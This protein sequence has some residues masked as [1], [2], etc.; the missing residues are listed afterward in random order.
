[1]LLLIVLL[2]LLLRKRKHKEEK[3]IENYSSGL[4][5]TEATGNYVMMPSTANSP[6]QSFVRPKSGIE[7]SKKF[8][9]IQILQL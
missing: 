1:M 6:G 9:R 7:N 4:E 2:I 8:L 5:L 3:K